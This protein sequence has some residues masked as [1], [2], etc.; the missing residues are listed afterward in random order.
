MSK[1]G[2]EAQKVLSEGVDAM[3]SVN[4]N[5]ELKFFDGF[6]ESYY[7]SLI[8]SAIEYDMD[9][10]RHD[11][12][13]EVDWDDFDVDYEGFKNRICEIFCDKWHEHAPSIVKAVK[14]FTLDSPRE[15]NFRTDKVY[16]DVE[17]QGDWKEQML[18]FMDAHKDALE[19]KINEDW[20][21]SDGFWSF[22]DHTFAGFREHIEDEDEDYV[23]IMIGY[24]MEFMESNKFDD[25]EIYN[26]ITEEV[27][28]CFESHE[29]A[30]EYIS[31][32]N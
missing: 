9:Y 1:V 31:C 26:L 20:S 18:F 17:L 22:I 30:S 23:G 10:L 14:S 21:S 24:M 32:K 29:G 19:K 13:I 28:D 2:E 8:D 27:V 6:V 7:D 25:N 11:E 4:M 12:G 3:D 16:A 5:I 15:Y